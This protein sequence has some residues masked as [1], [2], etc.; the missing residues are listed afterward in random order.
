MDGAMHDLT[1]FIKPNT[2]W[3]FLTADAINDK[4][5]IA[6]IGQIHGGAHTAYLLTPK[7]DLKP[8]R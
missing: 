6:G 1:E 7:K 3:T 4:G 5:E 8:S 2:G